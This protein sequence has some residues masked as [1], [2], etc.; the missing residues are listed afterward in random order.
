MIPFVEHPVLD[1]GPLSIHAFGVA[2]A[3]ALWV[4]FAMAQRR[5]VRV[6]LDVAIGQRL[7]AWMVGG[8][9]LGAHLFSVLFYFPEKLRSDPWLLLRLWEDISSFGGVMGG[10]IGALLF[11]ALR[12]RES[13]WHTR[14]AYLDA[15]AFVF[16]VALGIGRVG[17]ALAHDHPGVITSFPLAVSLETEAARFLIAGY[18]DAAALTVPANLEQLGFHDLGLYELLLLVLLIVPLFAFWSRRQRPA[19][20]YLVAFAALYL[21]VRFLLDTLRIADA[22]YLGLTPAQ[23]IAA[24]VLLLLPLAIARRKAGFGITGAL[25]LGTALACWSTTPSPAVSNSATADSLRVLDQQLQDA[26]AKKD[27]DRITS[28]Y[29]DDARM[30]PT[31]E[32]AIRGIQAIRAEWAHILAIPNFENKSELQSVD[33]SASGDL[34]YTMGSYESVMMGE[35]GTLVREPGKWVSIWK[36][37]AGGNWRIV[38][39]TYNTDVPPPDHK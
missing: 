4:G 2:V 29:D 16:P 39:D 18:Y 7:G 5:F 13:S 23:W 28:F 30:L 19:G 33:V 27:I 12:L 21:P 11:F 15:V 9:I 24:V 38:V 17:C 34:A 35:S 6:G 8:G 14:L 1:L 36:R 20:F 26:V 22:R 31:A 37:H 3:V 10:I 25:I 32:P